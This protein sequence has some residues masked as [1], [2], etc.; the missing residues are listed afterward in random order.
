MRK[1]RNMFQMKD[2]TKLSKK[3]VNEMEI[4]RYLPDVEFKTII[5]NV[6]TDLARGMDKHS[7]NINKQKIK[8]PIAAEKIQ[9]TE[10][11]KTLERIN[12]SLDDT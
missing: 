8:E 6:F 3:E 10:T 2:K 1:Q 12:R 9:L 7:K 11:N 5:L 4:S